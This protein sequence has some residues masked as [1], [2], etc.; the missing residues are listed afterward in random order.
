MHTRTP[1]RQR[2]V[3]PRLLHLSLAASLAAGAA[4]A[5]TATEA[6]TLPTVQVTGRGETATGPVDGYAATRSATATKTDTPLSETPQAVTVIPREQIIDQGAQNVQDTMNYAAG[7]RPNAYGVDNRGDY[8]RVRGV[9]PVQY[10]DGLKQFFNYNNPRTEVYG[11]ERVEVLRGPASMLYGQGSTGGVVNLVS[12]RPQPEAMREIGVTVGNHNRKEIQADL[13]GPLTEDGTWLYQV[14]ALG[15]DSDTQVQYTK[16]DRMMLAPSLTWQPSAATSLTLQAYWQKDK[17][18]TTQAFLPWS[19]TVSGN[20]N[21]RIPTRRFTSEPGFDRYDTEQFSVGWQFEHKF[22]DNWKVRQNLRHTSSKVDYS[23]LYPA[24]YGNPDNPFIDAD[25]RVVNRYLYIKNPRMRSLLADQ[26]LEGKVNW[27]RAE[28][29]LLMG[30]DYSRYRETGETGSGFG[31]PLDLYQP[32]YGTLPDYAMSD[33][34]KNKQQQIGVYLQDQIKFDRNWIVVAGLRHDRVA[35]S[36]EGADKET[37]NATTKRLGLMYAADNGWSPYLSYSESFTPI[38]GTDNSGNRWVPMRG[39][40]W[41]AGLK[42]MPQDTGYEA[43]LA[44]YDLRER[45]RQTNDPS[46]PTNQVQTG[47]TKTRGIELEFRGRVTPQM[48]VI[49]NYNYTDIDPQLEGLPKHTF[50]L[51]SKYRFSVGD[52]HGFAAGA[53][54]RYL[55]AFRDGSAPET[56]SVALFDA[57]LSYDTGSWRYALNVANIADKT[58]EVVCLRRG[59]CFYGQ[60]RTVTLSAMYR[61]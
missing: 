22:N 4:Q 11:L 10:L 57:M 32:V 40:Q 59:D 9:E 27:G 44:A 3:A 25:Q 51:W 45:N 46:D 47:K 61:F 36:V 58:Y 20:P 50:S 8:V 55:N 42:Y 24:V 56:G 18:G 49:A 41:E 39:K 31:A 30:V 60:R 13:T 14:V 23:T 1:Q 26:N 38:A 28:H 12:K 54:V 7:V 34:P 2:P 43:T 29:T 53:G 19:G 35:N 37:D 48:D 52:V 16:D 15:R 33:V 17:S 5:Q 21:G 6:T